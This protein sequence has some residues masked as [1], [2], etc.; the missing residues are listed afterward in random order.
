MAKKREDMLAS[1]NGLGSRRLRSTCVAVLGIL[2]AAG[3]PVSGDITV[4]GTGIPAVDLPAVQAAIDGGGI[5]TLKN[6]GANG[7][8]AFSFGAGG[9][10]TR[11]EVTIQGEEV[12]GKMARIEA[13]GDQT[14]PAGDKAFYID[15]GGFDNVTIKN[16]HIVGTGQSCISGYDIMT[17]GT[18]RIE[19]NVIDGVYAIWLGAIWAPQLVANYEICSNTVRATSFSIAVV[20]AKSVRIEDNDTESPYGIAAINIGG[21]NGMVIRD[22]AVNAFGGYN[23]YNFLT[24]TIGIRVSHATG[25]NGGEISGNTIAVAPVSVGPPVFS[26]G[27]CYGHDLPANGVVTTSNTVL[28]DADYPILLVDGSSENVFTAND[29]S[30]ITARKMDIYDASQIALTSDCDNNVFTNNT[31]GPL[32]DGATAGVAC[33]GNGNSFIQNDYRQSGIQGLSASDIPCVRLGTTAAENL[34]HESGRFPPGTGGATEQVLD[35]PREL[36]GTTT[37]RVVGHSADTLAEDI[38]PGVGQRVKDALAQSE[39]IPELGL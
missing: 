17:T 4:V 11:N 37:N 15:V 19:N 13:S 28:G 29:L 7:E 32:G 9:V 10:T 39:E 33:G 23:Y 36:L 2:I 30:G 26:V 16:C 18:V 25:F 20:D 34:V 1:V 24:I 35:L 3:T 12:A 8:I 38:N 27:L 21:N 22:N 6:G 14:W 31:I 5:V